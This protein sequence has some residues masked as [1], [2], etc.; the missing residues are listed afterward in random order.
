MLDR[1]PSLRGDGILPVRFSDREPNQNSEPT[2]VEG[3]DL[4]SLRTVSFAFK[5]TSK[6]RAHRLAVP[7]NIS[8]EVIA[9][10]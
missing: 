10:T 8:L 1:R 3:P 7:N 6:P 2:P 9:A 5:M 4:A